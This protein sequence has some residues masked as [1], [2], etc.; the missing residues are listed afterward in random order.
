[1]TA[2]EKTTALIPW[3]P[4]PPP[5]AFWIGLALMLTAVLLGA[6]DIVRTR[7]HDRPRPTDSEHLDR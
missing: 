4:A 5:G 7:W 2:A 1:M 3:L 6:G